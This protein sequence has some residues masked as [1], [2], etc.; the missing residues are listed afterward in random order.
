MKW[1]YLNIYIEKP[2]YILENIDPGGPRQNIL[3]ENYWTLNKKN[4]MEIQTDI[5]TDN[6][7]KSHLLIFNSNALSEKKIE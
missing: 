4:P 5:V 7:K 3:L 1:K 6:G 2:Y